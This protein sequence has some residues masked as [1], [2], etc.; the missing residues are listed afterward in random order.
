MRQRRDRG[1]TTSGN[2]AIPSQQG[3]GQIF[4]VR[5]QQTRCYYIFL[6]PFQHSE[7]LPWLCSSSS[8]ARKE[9]V[10]REGQFLMRHDVSI[11]LVLE[12]RMQQIYQF[13]CMIFIKDTLVGYRLESYQYTRITRCDTNIQKK[14]SW[15]IFSIFLNL[16]RTR[17]YQHV[18]DS[19]LIQFARGF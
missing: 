2:Y 7:L 1:T 15:K 13:H 11:S 16:L 9:Q 18:S 6:L 5:L 8:L 19:I 3:H 10:E 17:A 4:N 14:H 12:C